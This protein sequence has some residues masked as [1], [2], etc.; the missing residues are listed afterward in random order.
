MT[1]NKDI[2]EQLEKEL[3][4]RLNEEWSKDSNLTI[5]AA[6]TH[7]FDVYGESLAI[8]IKALEEIRNHRPYPEND[9]QN[10]FDNGFRMGTAEK[11]L[12]TIRNES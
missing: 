12:H 5:D 2:I 10:S 8:T 4:K 6:L 1:P 7:A 11:A 9:M 3:T